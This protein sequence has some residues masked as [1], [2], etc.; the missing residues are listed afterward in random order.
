M[1]NIFFNYGYTSGAKL[2]DLEYLKKS[3]ISPF[4]S[5]NGSQVVLFGMIRTEIVKQCQI[6]KAAKMMIHC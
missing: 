4:I 1:S 5:I 3:C 2:I 6:F